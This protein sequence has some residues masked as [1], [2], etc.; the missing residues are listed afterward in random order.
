MSVLQFMNPPI[1]Y[2]ITNLAIFCPTSVSYYLPSLNFKMF[3]GST[4]LIF[5]KLYSVSEENNH[6]LCIPTDRSDSGDAKFPPTLL[7]NVQTFTSKVGEIWPRYCRSRQSVCAKLDYSFKRQS[8][9]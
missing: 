5:Q 2:L 9:V 1:Y 3:C 7:A 6:F 4:V 8:I